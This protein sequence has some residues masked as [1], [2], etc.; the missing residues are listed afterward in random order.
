MNIK[1]SEVNK[2][3]PKNGRFFTV[4]FTKRT[5]G[6]LRTM[7]CRLGVKQHLKGGTKS[8]KDDDKNLLTVWDNTKHAYRSIPLE[9]LIELRSGG[10]VYHIVD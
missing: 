10:K 5:T 8:F 9:N 2:L 4:T 7:N 3:I 6:D 1:R